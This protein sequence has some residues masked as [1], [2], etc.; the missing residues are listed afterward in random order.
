[1]GVAVGVTDDYVLGAMPLFP[2]V[3]LRDLDVVI[4]STAATETSPGV[5]NVLWQSKRLPGNSIRYSEL[6]QGGV[7]RFLSPGDREKVDAS[8]AVSVL[9]EDSVMDRL[10]AEDSVRIPV[11]DKLRAAMERHSATSKTLPAGIEGLRNRHSHS[12]ADAEPALVWVLISA[13]V[14][15]VG[16]VL[17]LW[18]KLRRQTSTDHKD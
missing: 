7:L 12:K 2:R 10:R 16:L 18:R 8:D 6:H 4:E 15:S 3:R 13:L 9:R 14:V 1:M 5:G 11:A 17:F